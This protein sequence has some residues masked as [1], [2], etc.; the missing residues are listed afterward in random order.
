MYSY[1]EVLAGLHQIPLT[2]S[3]IVLVH[4]SYKSLGGVEGG[5]EAVIDALMAW[6]GPNGTVLLPNFN[7][8]SWTESH[9]FDVREKIGRASCRERV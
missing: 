6:V 1:Q 5:A 4:S 9:Y 8:Q 7:F 3:R 2:D